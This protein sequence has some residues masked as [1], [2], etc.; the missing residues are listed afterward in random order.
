MS[1][2]RTV[3]LLGGLPASGKST[4]AKKIQSHFETDGNLSCVHLEYDVFEDEISSTFQ[5]VGSGTKPQEARDNTITAWNEARKAAVA[6]LEGVLRK[7]RIEESLVVLM[8]DNYHLRGMRK[9]IHRLL[10]DHDH[11][12]GQQLNFGILWMET[13]VETCLQRNESRTR[14]VPKHVIQKMK[15]TL[16]KP[17]ANWEA[18]C[19]SISD[20]TPF[21]DILNFINNCQEI[22][23]LPQ[24]LVDQ[25]QQE[26]DRIQTSENQRH[27]WDNLLRSWVGQVAK[28]DKTLARSANAARKEVMTQ[29]KATVSEVKS[30]R[31]LLERFI[32][33]VVVSTD[34]ESIH[35]ELKSALQE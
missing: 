19:L 34:R 10:L 6:N 14:R 25:K 9:Q 27:D 8:D 3:M 21:G 2:S 7:A 32:D 33:Y 31:D 5:D 12:P 18:Y 23:E 30:E 29:I 13:D 17:R 11:G 35:E 28:Y 22:Q 26:K 24:D 1:S 4:L 15:D 16:E 20:E